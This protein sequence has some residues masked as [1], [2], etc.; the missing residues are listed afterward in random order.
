MSRSKETRSRGRRALR[1]VLWS[2][3]VLVGLC[4]AYVV[5]L[6]AL[7]A[8]GRLSALLRDAEPRLIVDV[9]SSY[10]VWPGR[11]EARN[12]SI[13]YGDGNLHITV[14]A[15]HGSFDVDLLALAKK[16]F[17]AKNVTGTGYVVHI[18]PNFEEYRPERRQALP[19][20]ADAPR[21][22]PPPDLDALWGVELSNVSAE[23][24]EIWVSELR[25]LGKVQL[26]GGFFYQPLRHLEIFP[27]ELSLDGGTA[28][29]G[30]CE[31]VL[32]G[33]R[34]MLRASLVGTELPAPLL[35]LVEGSADLKT[36]VKSLRFLGT[37]FPELHGIRGGAGPLTVN[38]QVSGGKLHQ[39]ATARYYPKDVTIDRGDRAVTLHADF[40]LDAPEK[41][42]TFA[43]R[44]VSPHAEFFLDKKR[45]AQ[46]ERAELRGNFRRTLDH[47]RLVKGS[48]EIERFVA[49][50]VELFERINLVPKHLGLSGGTVAGKLVLD[51]DDD[52]IDASVTVDL[53]GVAMQVAPFRGRTSGHASGHWHADRGT[54]LEGTLKNASLSLRDIELT[55]QDRKVSDWR[56]DVTVPELAVK[57]KPLHVTGKFTASTPDA[58]PPILVSGAVPTLLE[59]LIPSP[60]VAVNG[61]ADIRETTQTIAIDRTSKGDVRVSGIVKTTQRGTDAAFYVQTRLLDLGIIAR[62]SGT[63]MTLLGSDAWLEK[64]ARAIL[65]SPAPE[66]KP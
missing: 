30:E 37:L 41:S 52:D 51:A 63:E 54:P 66:R 9:G 24:D 14:K 18:R 45:V 36:N 15:P 44:A 7:I 55:S 50:D 40:S 17:V 35:R 61:T 21:G 23:L 34:G 19:P 39:K 1:V 4:V 47:P 48:V 26:R 42:Q 56:L 2:L 38:A 25:Y 33:T 13:D 20:L 57:G 53:D 29:F 43:A 64:E 32:E 58:K 65:G 8:S 22:G 46:V 60:A 11:V 10:S 62:P 3:G 16:R 5:I 28:S 12:L 27:S 59:K 49:T 6:N 31:P